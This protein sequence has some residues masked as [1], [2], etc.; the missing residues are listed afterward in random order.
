[1]FLNYSVSAKPRWHVA[2]M[3]HQKA[4]ILCKGNNKGPFYPPYLL[5]LVNTYIFLLRSLLIKSGAARRSPPPII[6]RL[7]NYL[8]VN[9]LFSED[10]S[11]PPPKRRGTLFSIFNYCCPVKIMKR[12]KNNISSNCRYVWYT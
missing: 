8:K 4:I 6:L 11:H 1:M 3:C 9:G 7:Y 2:A 12:F 5:N 10:P